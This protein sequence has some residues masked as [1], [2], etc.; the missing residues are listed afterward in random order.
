MRNILPVLLLILSAPWVHAQITGSPAVTAT[1][2]PSQSVTVNFGNTVRTGHPEVF[3]GN[4]FPTTDTAMQQDVVNQGVTFQRNIVEIRGDGSTCGI[5][6]VSTNAAYLAAI[7]VPGSVADPNTWNWGCFDVQQVAAAKAAGLKVELTINSAPQWSTYSGSDTCAFSSTK[8][9]V[10]QNLT[11]YADIVKKVYQHM[12]PDQV[13]I[14]NEPD[15]AL[16]VNG[17]PYGD[18]ASAYVAMYN[19]AAAAIRSVD[20]DVPI[21]GPD[22]CCSPPDGFIPAFLTSGIPANNLNFVDYHNYSDENDELFNGLNVVQLVHKYR[23]ELPV[24]VT[25]WNA[26]NV[27][28]IPR[29][30]SDPSSVSFVAMRLVNMINIGIDQADFWSVYGDSLYT[31]FT[32]GSLELLLPKT[33][34]YLLM[35]KKLGLGAGNYVVKSVMVSGVTTAMGAINSLG[36]NVVVVV[37]DSSSTLSIT[38]NM[39][40]LPISGAATLNLY[41]ATNTASPSSPYQVSSVTVM[42][43]SLTQAITM[44]GYSVTGLVL[45]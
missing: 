6:P 39:N 40:D 35:S 13:V 14:Y 3:G 41:R 37:N 24:Y 42:N 32:G 9:G 18:T 27:D 16:C 36:Q 34:T 7:G 31:F 33:G 20:A 23:R 45:Q 2:H 43:N 29:Y 11:V 12:L 21:G 28:S 10:P 26:P 4:R 8:A 5:L 38:V 15:Y 44:P 22:I 19:A 1:S 17:S 25:E 30:D